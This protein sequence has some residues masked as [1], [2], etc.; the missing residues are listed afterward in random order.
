MEK[1][2]KRQFP[3]LGL[4]K[5]LIEKYPD[6]P[7]SVSWSLLAPHEP[8]AIKNHDQTL[9]RLAQRGGLGVT[10]MIAVI[11]GLPWRWVSQ[12]S[13]REGQEEMWERLMKHVSE[14]EKVAQE[15]ENSDAVTEIEWLRWLHGTIALSEPE[16]LAEYKRL[17]FEATGKKLPEGY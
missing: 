15:K 11:E 6:R 9:E 12:N 13:R 2:G 14:T 16:E 8:Q 1:G 3:I 10:E 5:R 17:F 4:D 7:R